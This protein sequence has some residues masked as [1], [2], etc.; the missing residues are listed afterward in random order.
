MATEEMVLA[1]GNPRRALLVGLLRGALLAGALAG[2]G[3]L[4]SGHWG[5]EA[6]AVHSLCFVALAAAFLLPLR[7]AQ[8]SLP[9]ALTLVLPLMALVLLF[10][11]LLFSV[12]PGRSWP[13]FFLGAD[14]LFMGLAA[15]RNGRHFPRITFWALLLAAAVLPALQWQ[16]DGMLILSSDLFFLFFIMT[17]GGLAALLAFGRRDGAW[18]KALHWGP[19]LALL[20]MAVPLRFA[21]QAQRP[22]QPDP[23]STWAAPVADWWLEGPLWGLG[24]GFGEARNGPA[25]VDLQARWFPDVFRPF[26]EV[27]A[28]DRLSLKPGLALSPELGVWWRGEDLSLSSFHLFLVE[29]GLLPFALLVAFG[30]WAGIRYVLYGFLSGPRGGDAF[31]AGVGFLFALWG[32]MEA[33]LGHFAYPWMAGWMLAACLGYFWGAT[34]TPIYAERPHLGFLQNRWWR[35]T[36]AVGA[37]CLWLVFALFC[38]S[39][40][41]QKEA[42][43]G[44]G[45]PL[46]ARFFTAWSAPVLLHLAEQE[47]LRADARL[48]QATQTAPF[49]P[50]SHSALAGYFI[51]EGEKILAERA[52]QQGLAFCP[53]SLLLHCRLAAWA[54]QFGEAP[55]QAKARLEAAR[56]AGRQYAP[57]R[58]A[59]L[60]QRAEIL[61]RQGYLEKARQAWADFLICRPDHAVAQRRYRELSPSSSLLSSL[62]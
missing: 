48:E 56:L 45:I 19:L 25:A 22:L 11:N 1:L 8:G 53:D 27:T 31:L 38:L 33:V 7:P 2:S 13:A 4:E 41:G 35:G 37:F 32:I 6:L 44:K 26:V 36:L 3:W 62:P 51:E 23:A 50:A 18:R 30:L 60:Q 43:A 55:M 40:A 12:V 49:W 61:E 42:A 47:P 5:L 59:C 16:R 10:L 54:D 14:A 58:D 28:P 17:A 21:I 52:L 46:L 24:A 34:P 57:L 15:A 39:G 29:R 20:L 9:H